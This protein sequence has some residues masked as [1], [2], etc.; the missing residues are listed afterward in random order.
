MPS[1]CVVCSR[2]ATGQCPCGKV[3]YCGSQCQSSNFEIHGS[4]CNYVK[5]K[6]DEID[7]S[8]PGSLKEMLELQKQLKEELD[9]ISEKIYLKKKENAT[10]RWH[11][12]I[13]ESD[14]TFMKDLWKT[15]MEKT[16]KPDYDSPDQ[17]HVHT[18]FWVATLDD[19]FER[20]VLSDV[21]PA[22]ESGFEYFS[23]ESWADGYWRDFQRMNSL[24]NTC[25]LITIAEDY[26]Y[27][28]GDKQFIRREY[29]W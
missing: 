23:S 11:L 19:E 13:T 2:P 28:T 17:G 16:K 14:R 10:R 18:R 15:A 27:Y 8:K 21:F 22:F 6:A 1:V 20:P 25:N 24:M 5:R 4:V 26:T 29:L 7:P 9:D 12:L 3:Q